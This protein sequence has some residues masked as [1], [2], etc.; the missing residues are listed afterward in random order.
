MLA[1]GLATSIW[2]PTIEQGVRPRDFYQV[3]A[4]D[5]LEAPASTAVGGQR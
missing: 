2:M 3:K 4:I 5:N 1:M